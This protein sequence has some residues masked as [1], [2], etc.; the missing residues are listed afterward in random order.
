MKEYKITMTKELKVDF[1]TEANSKE[2][3]LEKYRDIHTAYCSNGIDDFAK[4]SYS[5]ETMGINY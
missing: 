5:V 4:I 3:A 2:E 1:Y